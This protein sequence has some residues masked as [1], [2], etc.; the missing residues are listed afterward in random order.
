MLIRGASGGVLPDGIEVEALDDR[1][2]EVV[3]AIV[4]EQ[5]GVKGLTRVFL[6][7]IVAPG[8]EGG[9]FF[10]SGYFIGD[11]LL[12]ARYEVVVD[13]FDGAF[14]RVELIGGHLLFGPSISFG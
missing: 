13:F 10:Y 1:I 6:F 9:E 5:V 3:C 7:Y 4:F 14:V 2:R 11:F 12:P 8:I